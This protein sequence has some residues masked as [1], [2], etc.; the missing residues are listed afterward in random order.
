M[1]RELFK[2]ADFWYKGLHCVVL[3]NNC[4]WRCG[5]VNVYGIKDMAYVDYVDCW[6]VSQR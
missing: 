2:E 6:F 5:Y 3:L 1:S 4:G